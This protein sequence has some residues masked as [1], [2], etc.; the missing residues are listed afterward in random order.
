MTNKFFRFLISLI[1]S[2]KRAELLKR[3]KKE[4]FPNKEVF[5][6]VKDFFDGNNDVGSI[7]VNLYPNQP[8]LKKFYDTLIAIE[9]DIKTEIL[10]VRIADIDDTEWFYADTVYISGDYSLNDVKKLFKQLKPDEIF[11]GKMFDKP[12]NIP[13]I[14]SDN[15]DYCVWWD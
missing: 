14:E 4:G 13:P 2:D 10:L 11:E 6:S 8:P 1:T 9:Q 7:G 12:S 3:I 5:V 15:K